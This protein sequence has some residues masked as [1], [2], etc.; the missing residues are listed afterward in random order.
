LAPHK[1]IRLFDLLHE[2]ADHLW[3]A[4][5]PLFIHQAI[6]ELHDLADETDETDEPTAYD[7]D[8]PIPF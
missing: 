1:I 4:H 7:D 2:L 8:N 3:D 6:A 5:E